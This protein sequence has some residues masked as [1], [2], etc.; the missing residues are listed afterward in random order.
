MMPTPT[1]NGELF[2]IEYTQR[3]LD[4]LITMPDAKQL[5][6]PESAAQYNLTMPPKMTVPP[7]MMPSKDVKLV[8]KT[9]ST[10]TVSFAATHSPMTGTMELKRYTK[11]S[12]HVWLIQTVV[13]EHKP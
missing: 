12:S 7:H 3:A 4:S 2:K 8:S 6:T 9:D 5:A 13:T 11:D 10:A 1:A